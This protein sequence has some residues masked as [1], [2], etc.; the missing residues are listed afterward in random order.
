MRH[1]ALFPSIDIGV[2]VT[3]TS[4]TDE[5]MV[6]ALDVFSLNTLIEW[7]SPVNTTTEDGKTRTAVITDPPSDLVLNWDP[8]L[9][10]AEAVHVTLAKVVGDDEIQDVAMIGEQSNTGSF[11][12]SV[13]VLGGL[14][15]QNDSY[16]MFKVI[17]MHCIDSYKLNTPSLLSKLRIILLLNTIETACFIGIKCHP[18]RRLFIAIDKKCA[19]K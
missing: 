16:V 3:A 8:S 7:G 18:V 6:D 14:G 11:V 9:M 5:T 19:V 12:A 13:D 2:M 1:N 10:G 17:T 15:L 4:A